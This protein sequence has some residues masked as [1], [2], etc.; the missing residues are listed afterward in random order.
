MIMP[1]MNRKFIRDHANKAVMD[2]IQIE[3]FIFICCLLK[4]ELEKTNQK[5]Q[6]SS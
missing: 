1:I 2:S 4:D 3:M 6:T 5:D